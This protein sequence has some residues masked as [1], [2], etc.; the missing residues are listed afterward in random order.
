MSSQPPYGNYPSQSQ[1]WPEQPPES[2]NPSYGQPGEYP[3]PPM[4]GAAPYPSQPMQ[5][6]PPSQPVYPQQPPSGAYPPPPQGYS[7]PNI[8]VQ[9]AAYPY[10]VA[11][12]AEPGSGQ[13]VAG[14]VLG[15]VSV[16]VAF[17]PCLGLA[18]PVTG[19][20]G[21]IMGIQGRKSVSRH[22]MA[23]TGIVLSS[24]GIGLSVLLVLL[25]FGLGIF[26]AISTPT[27]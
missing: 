15:I 17:I 20:I 16:V 22:G 9:P 13:A 6:T 10:I 5:P 19:I 11:A 24:I 8:Y 4:Y 21:L 7:A 12:P 18:S 23:V 2:T 3:P 1:P 27:N 25:Y 26:S 14:L